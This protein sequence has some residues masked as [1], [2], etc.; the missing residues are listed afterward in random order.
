VKPRA[1]LVAEPAL[2]KTRRKRISLDPGAANPVQY[3]IATIMQQR[4]PFPDGGTNL[5]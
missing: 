3:A 1:L 5:Q 4:E 2:R